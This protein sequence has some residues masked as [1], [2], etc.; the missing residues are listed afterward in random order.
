MRV[1]NVDSQASDSTIV[2]QVIGEMS[3][4]SQPHRKFVQTF[5]LASQ[6]NGYFV[7]NDIFR[8]IKDDVDEEEVE[9][10]EDEEIAAEEPVESA[11]PVAAEETVVEEKEAE[12]LDGKL[13]EVAK[14]EAEEKEAAPAAA[15]NG[16][17]VPESAE[18]AEADEAPAAAVSAP[19]AAKSE[20]LEKEVAEEDLAEPEKPTDPLPTPKNEAATP[21]TSAPAPAAAAPSAPPKPAVPRSWAQLAAGNQAKAAAAS[22]PAP[23]AAP[24]PSAS[25][26]KTTP[27]AP[28]AQPAAAPSAPRDASPDSAKEGSTGGWQTA[29]ADHTRKP[30]KPANAVGGSDGRVRAFV[31]NVTEEVDA[32]ALKSVLA[33]FGE[34]VYFD[35]ARQKVCRFPLFTFIPFHYAERILT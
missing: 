21:A 10:G 26:P 25:Q 7:L 6:T 5:I 3:N 11:A 9:G 28:A 35:V 17:P 32:D 34:I 12:I 29:G 1:T 15:V 24:A 8:Y 4:K 33:K 19:D 18:V 31:K 27:S 23:R 20:E 2:I 13:E 16:T 22:A 30:S 14:S